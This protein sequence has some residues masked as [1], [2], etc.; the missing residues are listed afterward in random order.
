MIRRPP[1]LYFSFRSPFSWMTV[2]RLRRG[3]PDIDEHLE[4]LP[5]WDPDQRTTAALTER[6]AG[7]HY[8]AMSKAKHLYILQ[9]TKRLAARLDLPMVWP[10]DLDPWWE[11]PH[12]AWLR[13]RRLG[14][15]RRFYD[16]V[17][18]ARWL[19]AENICEPA[20][21][22]RIALDVG[23]DPDLLATAADDEEIRAEGVDC[24]VAA[25][26]DNVFGIPYLRLGWQG[27]WGIDRVED[28][29]V[30]WRASLDRPPDRGSSLTIPAALVDL[31]GTYDT[32]TAGGCG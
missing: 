25:W 18:A 10:V 22:R 31:V 4:F 26:E 24:L 1:R 13:A 17:V 2:E 5:Y 8:V 11:L 21:I 12:L 28:F 16:A 3:M 14:L 9:D 15:A 19:R 7:L 20:V 6:G 29:L 27:F 23:V 32:D 30:A